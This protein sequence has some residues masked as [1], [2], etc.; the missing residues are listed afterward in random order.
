MATQYEKLRRDINRIISGIDEEIHNY[1]SPYKT[2]VSDEK[3]FAA[4]RAITQ[5]S[6]MCNDLEEIEN[7][8][9]HSVSHSGTKNT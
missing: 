7:W 5:L 9:R 8:R 2:W 1:D 4:S 6:A 3:Y